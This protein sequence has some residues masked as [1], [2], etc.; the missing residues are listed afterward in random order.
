MR[1]HTPSASVLPKPPDSYSIYQEINWDAPWV[2]VCLRVELPFWL[3]VDN[4]TM[5]IEVGG[6]TFPVAIHGETFELHGQWVS[7][8]K[9]NVLH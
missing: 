5:P 3:M 7:D 4:I 1:G 8:S 6:H 2:D 9:Q